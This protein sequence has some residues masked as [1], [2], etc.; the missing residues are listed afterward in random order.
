MTIFNLLDDLIEL[1][2]TRGVRGS[3][4]EHVNL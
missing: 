3:D 4:P 2:G 1:S